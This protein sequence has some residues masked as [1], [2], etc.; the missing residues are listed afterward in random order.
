[1]KN[2]ECYNSFNISIMDRKHKIIK[3]EM[4]KNLIVLHI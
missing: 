3:F 4:D 2:M 1:M